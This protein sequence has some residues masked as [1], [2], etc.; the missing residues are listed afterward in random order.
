MTAEQL[1]LDLGHRQAFGRDDFLVAESNADAVAWID[2]WPDWPAASGKLTGLALYGPKGSG[3]THLTHVWQARN[4][5]IRLT[6]LAL[7]AG[8]ELV[9]NLLA[10]AGK[11]H[12]VALDDLD[13]AFQDSES[14]EVLEEALLHLFNRL[15]DG[16]GS[17]LLTSETAPAHWPLSNTSLSSRLMALPTVG[18]GEPDDDLMAGL[19]L[20][21]F[22]D[23]QLQVPDPVI[24]F[25]ITHM[26]RSC[27]TARM[28][29]AAID[30]ASLAHQRRIT[31]PL[32]RQV[33][34]DLLQVEGRR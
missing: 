18:L 32:V 8:A 10:G 12:A 6:A 30:K 23:R 17:L 13:K 19:L 25:L 15:V 14:Q 5:A 7:S 26:E 28:V 24:R 22:D 9:D 31:I 16:G 27:G 1:T 21:L 3:K 11:N 29:V 2:R 33:L 4:G 20:K 34:V